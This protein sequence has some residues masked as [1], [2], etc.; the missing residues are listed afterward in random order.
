[1]GRDGMK[2]A[3]APSASDEGLPTGGPSDVG[4]LTEMEHLVK[5]HRQE[6]LAL[7]PRV[8]WEP[9]GHGGGRPF[10]ARL[11]DLFEPGEVLRPEVA[12]GREDLGEGGI[13]GRVVR[14]GRALPEQRPPTLDRVRLAEQD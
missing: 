11:P 6:R 5:R 1:M 14:R 9:R 4:D 8:V 3:D 7:G 13:N 2:A 12:E 10:E